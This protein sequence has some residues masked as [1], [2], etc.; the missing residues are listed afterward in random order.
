MSPLTRR[1]YLSPPHIGVLERKFLLDA[2]DSNWV[3]PV[4]PDL[5]AFEQAVAERIGRRRAVGLASGTASLHLALRVLGVGPGDTV[6]VPSFTFAAPANAVTYVG[7]RPTFV[8]SDPATWTL[9]PALVAEELDR[10][11]PTG[12]LPAAVVAVDIYGQCCDYAPLL[13]ACNRHGVPLVEDAAEALG[14]TYRGQEAGSFGVACALSFNGNKIITTSG[15]GMLL[16]DDDRFADEVRHLATQAREPAAHYEHRV[17]GHNYRLS[18]LLAAL[19]RGQLAALDERVTAR[20]EVNRLYRDLLDGEPGLQFMPF[21]GYGEPNAWLTCMLVDPVAFGAT[22]DEILAHL[23]AR[24]IEARPVWKPMHQQPVFAGS[25]VLG[26][27]V[28]EHL[29]RHGLC[30]PSGSSLS[31]ADQSRVVEA[32]HSV[33][34]RRGHRG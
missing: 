20:R 7:A 21:A 10:A 11:A 4:G 15:G 33:R 28:S 26:G 30:L 9:D 6:L 31:E 29:F 8:D 27:A 23:T 32:I 2:L 17:V 18:N 3:A 5:D 34:R 14:A 25:T 13:A 16:T 19:G 24:D 12:R 1:I 22:R